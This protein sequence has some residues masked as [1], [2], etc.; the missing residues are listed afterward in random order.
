MKGGDSVGVVHRHETSPADELGRCYPERV[1][2]L[3]GFSFHATA[4]G[5][6]A[7]IQKQSPKMTQNTNRRRTETCVTK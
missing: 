4:L 7:G 2:V 6:T 5:V 1:D 3:Q